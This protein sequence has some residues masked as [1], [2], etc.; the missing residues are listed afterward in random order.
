[1]SLRTDVYEQLKDRL[2]AG[3]LRTGQF[4]SQR[5]LA[6]LLGATLNPVRG[7]TATGRIGAYVVDDRS[8]GATTPPLV[9]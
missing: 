3:E 6:D 7:K 9:W 2:L 5:E 1:M 8:A 4:V